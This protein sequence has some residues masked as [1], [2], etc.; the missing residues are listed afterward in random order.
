M[1][2]VILSRDSGLGQEGALWGGVR[3]APQ[4]GGAQA[5]GGRGPLCPPGRPALAWLQAR[6]PT[7]P[8]DQAQHPQPPAD[9]VCS[10]RRPGCHPQSKAGSLSPE[11]SLAHVVPSQTSVSD[12]C[13]R[14]DRNAKQD[15]NTD[16]RR[17][18]NSCRPASRRVQLP[19]GHAGR[20]RGLDRGEEPRQ[21]AACGQACEGKGGLRVAVGFAAT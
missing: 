15:P 3:G 1:T 5:D 17:W 10:P 12:V 14:P 4:R 2:T 11:K 9:S 13:F 16:T 18:R 21:G 19:R 7:A 6:H 20:S 8:H